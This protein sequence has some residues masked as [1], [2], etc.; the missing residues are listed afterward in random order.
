MDRGIFR[1]DTIT[2]INPRAMR[3]RLPTLR[4]RGLLVALGYPC[5]ALAAAVLWSV[6]CGA[7]FGASLPI[8]I[9]L[10]AL[11][12]LA[13]RIEKFVA[14]R[15]DVTAVGGF[16]TAAALA[17]GPLAGVLAGASTEIFTSGSV[18][19]KRLAWAGASA[20][21]GFGIGFAGSRVGL[22]ASGEMALAIAALGLAVGLAINLLNVL[23]IG[24]DRRADLR[25]ELAAL[26][27]ATVLGWA[28]PWPALAAFLYAYRQ[29]PGVATALGIGLL[30]V[31]ALGNRLRLSL[32]RSLAEE[33][34][35]SRHD[36]LTGAPNRYALA[37]AL[38]IEHAQIMRGGQPGVICF[39]DLDRFR[40][41]NNSHGYSA[42]DALLVHVYERLRKHLRASDQLFRWG[43]EEFVV[44]APDQENIAEFAER[45]R[46]LFSDEP[47]AIGD[48]KITLTG[49]VGAARLDETRTAEAA[50]EAAARLVRVA[51]ARRNAIE[52][53]PPQRGLAPWP[54][55]EVPAVG[56][57]HTAIRY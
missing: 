20:L 21:N 41:V 54:I 17:G 49:S 22:H 18:W 24:L 43:G 23:I 4:G 32:E 12:S 50:L 33:R 47:F 30:A 25:R 39:L 19:R 56:I 44:I 28:L 14:P 9:A 48:R 5:A 52:V 10:T 3:T 13:A 40:E 27:R 31:L 34:L 15:T 38:A 26:W 1:L 29:A 35:R 55:R 53:E 42:G 37:E 46:R 16:I 11:V 6:S 51:K 8:V 7:G 45:L 57:R 2:R 36:A